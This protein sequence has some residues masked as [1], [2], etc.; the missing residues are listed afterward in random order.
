MLLIING[1]SSSIKFAIFKQ[2]DPPEKTFSGQINNIGK[3]NISLKTLKANNEVA[4]TIQLATTDYP[5]SIDYLVNWLGSNTDFNK[6][7]TIVHRIVHG[8]QHSAPTIINESLLASLK[9]IIPYDPDHLPN[10]INLMEVFQQHHPDKIH[11]ACFDTAFHQTMPRVARL[12]PIPR[13][14][15]QKGIVRYGFHGLSYQYLMLALEKIA[16]RDTANG[17]VVLAHLGNGASLAAVHRGQSMD[18]SMAFTPAS[19]IP[20]STRSG[21]ID[22]GVAWYIM[23]SENLSADQFNHLINH[24]SGLLGMAATSGDMADLLVRESTDIRAEEA[25][26]LFCYEVRKKIGA[27]AAALGGIDTLVFSGG[28]GENAAIIRQRVCK[29][30]GFLGIDLDTQRNEQNNRLISV[31]NGKVAVRVIS[32]DEEWMMAQIVIRMTGH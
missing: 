21:D 23:K 28:I 19:G 12:L 17:R 22:P 30:L 24:E 20:M 6:I 14:F 8:M 1:G 2:S 27:Y 29:Q 9:Q 5:S 16:G 25:I 26:N 18:T 11:I 4:E 10:E 7:T 32:T 3:T 15:E 31:D 13:R